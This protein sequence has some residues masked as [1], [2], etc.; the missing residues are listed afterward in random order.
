MSPRVPGPVAP[1]SVNDL[2]YL[3]NPLDGQQEAPPYVFKGIQ[4]HYFKLR[5]EARALESFC[6]RYLNPAS[7]A[8]TYWP[9]SSLPLL[10]AGF[11]QPFV[12]LGVLFYPDMR[13]GSF[14][15]ERF[16]QQHEVFF[17]F[18]VLRFNNGFP[19]RICWVYPFICVDNIRSAITGRE[20][21]GLSKLVGRFD[22]LDSRPS[23]A[24]HP[25]SRDSLSGELFGDD[26]DSMGISV[27]TYM[28]YGQDIHEQM[29][30]II[31]VQADPKFQAAALLDGEVPPLQESPVLDRAAAEARACFGPPWPAPDAADAGAVL[32]RIAEL[33]QGFTFLSP[34]L[35]INSLKQTRSSVDP[36][37]SDHQA[38]LETVWQSENVRQLR[39][40]GLGHFR[41]QIFNQAGLPLVNQLGLGEHKRDG[42][43][44]EL[45]GLG[46]SYSL[47]ADLRMVSA[48]VLAE[49][50]ADGPTTGSPLIRDL[51]TIPRAC[52][53]LSADLAD[54]SIQWA[55]L[56]VSL[57]RQVLG[58]KP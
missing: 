17:S 31:R 13:S 38:L 23:G 22:C 54:A 2:P 24:P 44:I 20:V 36:A 28:R 41:I 37:Y 7:N 30:P 8:F 25:P 11:G 3:D 49:A 50:N 46:S 35:V 57:A 12:V 45:V 34:K 18:P 9:L 48:S 21:I 52:L 16:T 15:P 43:F 58:L 55:G 33:V 39:F 14:H 1:A 4:S 47:S 26:T 19:D 40:W 51:A 42:D 29:L 27:P 53:S 5:A 10:G 56:S 32:N 6:S